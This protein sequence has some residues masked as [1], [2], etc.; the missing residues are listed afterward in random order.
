MNIFLIFYIISVIVT[1]VFVWGW[2]F[3]YWENKFP[4]HKGNFFIALFFS[5]LLA[6]ESLLG[7]GLT[8]FLTDFAKFGW[9]NPFKK[10]K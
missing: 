2:S 7:F 3:A 6:F 5:V 10:I 8:L 9:Q 1:F 4:N